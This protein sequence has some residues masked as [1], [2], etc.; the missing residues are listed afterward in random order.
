M[1]CN[2]V[3]KLTECDF[4]IVYKKERMNFVANGLSRNIKYKSEQENPEMPRVELQQ[5]SMNDE[6]PESSSEE[7]TDFFIRK[8]RAIRAKGG[9]RNIERT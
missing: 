7:S 9:I 1:A 6:V 2:L 4:D 8:T 3:S 5:K